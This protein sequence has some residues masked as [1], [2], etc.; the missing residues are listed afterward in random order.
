[1]AGNS[2]ARAVVCENAEQVAKV[3]AVRERLPN[4]E[5]I[6]VVDPAGDVADAISLDEVRERGRGVEPAVLEQR[7]AAVTPADP[8]TFIYTS[9]TTG[10]AQGLRALPRQLPRRHGHVPLDQC[11]PRR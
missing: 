10:P 2:E 4:M 6:I 9:G 5:T 8:F 1:M 3:V 11:R 7:T